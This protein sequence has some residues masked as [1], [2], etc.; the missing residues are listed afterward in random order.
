MQYLDFEKP[1]EELNNK[2]IQAKELSDIENVDVAK[3]LEKLN[4]I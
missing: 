2:L 4:N 1:L 3:Q